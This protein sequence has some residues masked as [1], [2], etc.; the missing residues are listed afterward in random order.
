[1]K[2]KEVTTRDHCYNQLLHAKKQQNI[3]IYFLQV[4]AQLQSKQLQFASFLLHQRRGNH[5]L[6]FFLVSK[7]FLYLFT[8]LT[9]I[10]NKMNYS[11]IHF[12]KALMH[13]KAKKGGYR[14]VEKILYQIV[15]SNHMI[16]YSYRADNLQSA[17]GKK[18]VHKTLQRLL[19]TGLITIKPVG[20]IKSKQWAFYIATSITA[21]LRRAFPIRHCQIS[22]AWYRA[23]FR[24]FCTRDRHRSRQQQ[25]FVEK[26]HL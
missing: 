22:V 13:Q 7:M 1:M 4:F 18:Y 14:I 15:S 5:K 25:H 21:A 26:V 9:Y 6:R 12:E 8:Y 11:S 16:Y 24:V 19:A 17:T 3:P 20:P 2:E 23:P 10:S